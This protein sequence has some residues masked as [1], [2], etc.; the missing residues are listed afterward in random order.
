MSQNK[1]RFDEFLDA[2]SEDGWPYIE[3]KEDKNL[4][5]YQVLLRQPRHIRRN[6]VIEFVFFIP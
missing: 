5:A 2:L 3:T 6:Q 1:K 4:M